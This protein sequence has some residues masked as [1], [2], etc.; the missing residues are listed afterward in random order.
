MRW[1][2][3]DGRFRRGHRSGSAFGPLAARSRRL[4]FKNLPASRHSGFAARID[5][6]CQAL[7]NPVTWCHFRRQ[8]GE[9]CVTIILRLYI[10]MKKNGGKRCD[11]KLQR[12]ITVG[13]LSG[14]NKTA[15]S[16]PPFAVCEE[17]WSVFAWTPRLRVTFGK[18]SVELCCALNLCD[19][20]SPVTFSNDITC[21]LAASAQN[22]WSVFKRL[23]LL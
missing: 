11:R 16:V 20:M 12:E 3:P 13:Q 22:N 2:R 23:T 5:L 15:S 4:R 10:K 8:N 9:F 14:S 7:L 21:F 17:M 6:L 18:E 19:S 1:P